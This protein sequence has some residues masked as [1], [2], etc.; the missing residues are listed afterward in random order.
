MQPLRV[1]ACLTVFVLSAAIPAFAQNNDAG[2]NAPVL[3]EGARLILGPATAPPLENGS[4]LVERGVITALGT[5]GQV[6]APAGTLRVDLSGKTVMPAL[7][8]VHAHLGYEKYTSAAGD[9]RAEHYT[10]EN[11]LD[12]FQRSAFYGV[13]TVNDGGTAVVP[14]SLQF[15]ADQRSGKYPP[16]ARYVFNP[17][18]VPPGGGPD[19]IL[20]RGTRPL[21]ANY[22]VSDANEAREAIRDIAA[23]GIGHIKIWI[24]DRGGTYPPMTKDVSDAIID[25]AHKHAI[26]VHA[27]AT[28]LKDQKEIV[29]AGADVL[30][31]MVDDEALDD[32][33]LALLGGK[34]PFWVPLIG[35]GLGPG[36]RR[37]VCNNE[38]F[39]TQTLSAFILSDIMESDC[40]GMPDA[41]ERRAWFDQNFAAMMNAGARI[42]LGTDAGVR[43][44]KT[45]GSAAH[46]ELA[47]FVGL[48]MSEAEAIEAGTSRAAE[49]LGIEDVG[50]LAIGKDADFL[51]L[52]ANPLVDIRNTRAISAVYLR[53]A[54]LDR[55]ALLAKWQGG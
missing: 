48:G 7:I 4:F 29:T 35:Y 45:F 43:P 38:P 14:L 21:N 19:H 28:S 17:G 1:L 33:Y 2:A 34:R 51:V 16:A 49:A 11:L 24:D 39:A 32:E 52:D 25:E 40:G 53:G 15:L 54:K 18:V 8:D 27:H 23:K 10:A 5:G 13:G 47:I 31:H 26:D 6:A 46:H 3:Y 9:S 20:I 22:E 12:H 44:S 30:L 37:E 55:D 50:V 42:V 36:L 41:A